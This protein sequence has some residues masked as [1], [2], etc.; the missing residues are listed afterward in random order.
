MVRGLLR[1]GKIA[2]EQAGMH[3]CKG[4]RPNGFSE[5]ARAQVKSPGSVF[6]MPDPKPQ[7]SY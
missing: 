7:I 1:A 3:K 5:A 2:S 4:M 6:E